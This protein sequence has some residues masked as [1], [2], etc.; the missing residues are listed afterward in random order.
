MSRAQFSRGDVL[1][2]G[3]TYLDGGAAERVKRLKIGATPTGSEEDTGFDLPAKAIIKDVWVDVATAEATGG[4]KTLDVGLLSSET[5][6]DADGFLNGVSVSTTGIK[7]GSLASGAQTLGAF[8]SID[9][10]GAGTLVP[11]PHVVG[12]ARS[13]TFTAGSSDFAEFRGSVFVHYIE[14]E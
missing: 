6:G 13:V 7:R 12:S 11:R 4:T 5:N 3:I 1:A 2:G 14:V 9:E 10:D 8:L